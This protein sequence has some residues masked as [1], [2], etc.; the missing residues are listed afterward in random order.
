MDRRRFTRELLLAAATLP[1]VARGFPSNILRAAPPKKILILGG[2][3]FLGPAC[4]DAAIIAGHT[5]TL[6]NRGVTNPELY[7]HLEKLRGYRDPDPTQQIFASL[8]QRHWDAIIDVWPS[9]P[10]LVESAAR[11]LAPRTEHYLFVSSIAAYDFNDYARPGLTESGL[12]AE[13]KGSSASYRRSKAESERRLNSIVGPR[14]TI[15]RPGPIKGDRD[16]TPDLYTWLVRAQSGKHIAP[17]SGDDH[18]QMVDVKDVARFLISAID[19][20]IYGTYNLTG[21]ALTFRQFIDQVRAVEP[22]QGAFEWVPTE[23]LHQHGLD[24]DPSYIGRFPLW[25]PQPDQIGFFQI[26]SQKALDAGWVTR[27][28]VETAMDC[29][30]YFALLT[31]NGLEWTDLLAPATEK[32]LLQAWDARAR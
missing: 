7:P 19:R 5:V 17:G 29:L 27:P 32:Q 25:H 1:R 23:F 10:S 12:L 30:Y 3:N 11:L 4:V 31:Q 21:R 26:S 6:F 8:A 16:T 15:V 14:L 22:G 9:D 28:F 18:V 20:S 13:W 2:T 24:P